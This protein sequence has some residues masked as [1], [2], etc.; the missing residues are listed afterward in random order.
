MNLTN[1]DTIHLNLSCAAAL[2]HPTLSVWR[3]NLSNA[4]FVEYKE[5]LSKVLHTY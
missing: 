5:C 1:H 4:Y 2:T 3:S